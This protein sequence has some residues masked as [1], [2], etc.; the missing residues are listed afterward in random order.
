[1]YLAL[2]LGKSVE[3][4]AAS[5]PVV[6]I[7]HVFF[8]NS[9]QLFVSRVFV[10]LEALVECIRPIATDA[11]GNHVAYKVAHSHNQRVTN[12]S[13]VESV[14]FRH[15]GESRDLEICPTLRINQ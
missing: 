15:E 1:V 2:E 5:S 12:W 3:K 4:P 14:S 10:G 6:E 13:S 11:G 7:R 8:E 9:C